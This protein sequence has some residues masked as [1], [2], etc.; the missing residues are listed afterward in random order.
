MKRDAIIQ[1]VF[2]LTLSFTTHFLSVAQIDDIWY[3]SLNEAK[4]EAKQSDKL[5]IVEFGTEY[6]LGNVALAADVWEDEKVIEKLNLFVPVYLDQ[7]I[8]RVPAYKYKI[9]RVPTL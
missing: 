9:Y 7:E 1:G 4:K 6:S 2:L 8:D 5:I 3:T